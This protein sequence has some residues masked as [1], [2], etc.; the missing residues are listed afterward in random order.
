MSW[1][2]FDFHCIKCGFFLEEETRPELE[3]YVED[4]DSEKEFTKYCETASY[5]YS[6]LYYKT[7][8]NSNTYHCKNENCICKEV[9]SVIL[10]HPLRDIGSSAGDS[11]AFGIQSKIENDIFCFMCGSVVDQIKMCCTGS[12]CCFTW[13]WCFDIISTPKIV[14]GLGYIK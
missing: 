10:F 8:G 14:F 7:F 3:M 12:K 9:H 4:F 6:N 1:S 11:L 5:K 2:G 13:D